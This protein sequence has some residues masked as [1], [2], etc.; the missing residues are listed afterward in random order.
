LLPLQCSHGGYQSSIG[1][2]WSSSPWEV[3][4]GD[5]RTSYGGGRSSPASD[6]YGEVVVLPEP[7]GAT[8]NF[9]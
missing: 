3:P 2:W 1:Y 6:I 8:T 7:G 9:V 4:A 5:R